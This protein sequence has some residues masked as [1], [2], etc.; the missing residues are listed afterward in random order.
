[1][2]SPLLLL[3]A[4]VYASLM[5]QF[6]PF[7]HVNRPDHVFL[8]ICTASTISLVRISVLHLFNI[9]NLFHSRPYFLFCSYRRHMDL[10]AITP[11]PSSFFIPLNAKR[12]PLLVLCY[13]ADPCLFFSLTRP[14]SFWLYQVCI[15]CP[16]LMYLHV[17][18][19]FHVDR[20]GAVHVCCVGRAH[21]SALGRPCD[22]VSSAWL[23]TMGIMDRVSR[24]ASGDVGEKGT[25]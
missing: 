19:H 20:D 6:M 8:I 17:D 13:L 16:H 5:T 1:M 24:R 25:R 2:L 10:D 15:W 18:I 22:R 9:F 14:F 12:N 4:H 21:A 3:A 23:G 7:F 11:F